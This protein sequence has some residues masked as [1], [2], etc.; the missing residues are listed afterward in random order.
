M[1]ITLFTEDFFNAAH[2][3][4]N[5]NGNCSEI[6]GHSWKVEVWIRGEENQKDNL[7]ILWDF[8][9][10]KKIVDQ[11]DHK[12]LNNILPE[13]PTVENI[14]AF[15]YKKIKNDRKDLLFKVR[16]YESIIKKNAYCELGDF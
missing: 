10:L 14:T 8:N 13:N 1:T 12:N 9:N 3:L 2:L 7:G 5:Y 16:V 15:I 6:H 4:N 11:F